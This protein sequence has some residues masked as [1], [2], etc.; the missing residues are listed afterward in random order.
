MKYSDISF[1]TILFIVIVWLF[2]GAVVKEWSTFKRILSNKYVA[3]TTVGLM[4][5]LLLL[6][7]LVEEF[8]INVIFGLIILAAVIGLIRKHYANRGRIQ[9]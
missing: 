2:Y 5:A 9:E 8:P 4:W 1:G 6:I 3:Y 7:V